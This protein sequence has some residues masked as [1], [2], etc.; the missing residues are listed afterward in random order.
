MRLQ[1]RIKYLKMSFGSSVFCMFRKNIS[2]LPMNNLT[3]RIG[4]HVK[5]ITINETSEFEYLYGDDECF[6][7]LTRRSIEI[8][9]I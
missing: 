8:C 2:V 3:F 5:S 1:C 7:I 4:V 6:R 9:I